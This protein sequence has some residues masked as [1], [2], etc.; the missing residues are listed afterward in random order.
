MS[1]I[2]RSIS[3]SEITQAFFL[4]APASS[5]V[6]SILHITVKATLVLYFTPLYFPPNQI[7]P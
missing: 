4:Q 6:Q 5:V 3:D 1:E 2:H 7:F